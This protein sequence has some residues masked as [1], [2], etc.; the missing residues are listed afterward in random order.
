MTKKKFTIKEIVAATILER[1]YYEFILELPWLARKFG[2]SWINLHNRYERLIRSRKGPGV[3][4]DWE[5][6]RPLFLCNIYPKIA[7]KVARSAFSKWPIK[8]ANKQKIFLKDKPLISFIIIHKGIERMPL[9]EF[10]IKSIFGQSDIPVECIIIDQSETEALKERLLKNKDLIEGVRYHHI[11]IPNKSNRFHKAWA[12]NL[13]AKM[14]KA[15]ILVFHDGDVII[16]ADYSREI[17]FNFRRQY[18][19]VRL[20]R[21]TFCLSHQSTQLILSEGASALEKYSQL[22]F[23]SVRQNEEGGSIAVKKKTFFELGGFDEAFIGYGGEDNEFFNRCLSRKAYI[24]S[25]LPFMHL[26]HSPQPEKDNNN[27]K[28]NEAY[29]DERLKIS[30]KARI[31]ELIKRDF[32]SLNGPHKINEDGK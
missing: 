29:R 1:P 32:G 5:W 19:V 18:E 14:A 2:L 10:V 28:V 13:G 17:V 20:Q 23:D 4:C 9:V 21:F 8:L 24:Y 15:D 6:T 3:I 7:Q 26:F 31:E 30:H 12:F 25:Y 11:P 27:R 16:P 22:S